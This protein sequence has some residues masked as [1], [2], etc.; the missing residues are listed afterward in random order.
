MKIII[1][2]L[3]LSTVVFAQNAFDKVAW[4]SGC[5][6]GDVDEAKY[7]ECWTS[8]SGEFMQGSGRM[9]KGDKILMREHITIEKE[10]EDLIMYV[11]GYGEKL[12]PDAQGTV[13]FKLVKSS[14]NELVF[15]NPKHDYPQRI[16]YA[17]DGK[18]GLIARIELIDGKNQTLFK[19]KRRNAK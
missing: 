15:E 1:T 5:W 7:E 18:D 17:K 3:L 12:K 10:G 14:K 13:G 11:L 19:L 8:P 9:S 2:I 6:I 16:V 4:F